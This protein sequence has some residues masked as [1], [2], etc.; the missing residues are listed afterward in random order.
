[1]KSILKDTF[2]PIIFSFSNSFRII[3][4]TDDVRTVY[5]QIGRTLVSTSTY[6]VIDIEGGVEIHVG[7]VNLTIYTLYDEETE[8]R[9]VK[10]DWNAGPLTRL[11]DC[12]DFGI[13]SHNIGMVQYY[14]MIMKRGLDDDTVASFT[15]YMIIAKECNIILKEFKIQKTLFLAVPP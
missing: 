12:I 6:T 8:A 4:F 5:G 3:L 15:K 9:G 2:L 10:F 7:A 1:M 14:F 11:E 13:N